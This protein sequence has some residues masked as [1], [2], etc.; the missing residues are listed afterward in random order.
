MPQPLQLCV[1]LLEIVPKLFAMVYGVRLL[2]GDGNL[3]SDS[4]HPRRGTVSPCT[5][6][7]FWLAG[8]LAFST[9]GMACFACAVM[10]AVEADDRVLLKW[11]FPPMF[12]GHPRPW[13]T[14]LKIRA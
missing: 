2:K 11:L 5:I 1:A 12:E 10:R 3:P 7:S 6:L 9:L 13:T 14:H 8:L 4:I